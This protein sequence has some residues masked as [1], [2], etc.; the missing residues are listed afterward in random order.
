M[1]PFACDEQIFMAKHS[2]TN[3]V[4]IAPQKNIY[5]NLPWSE[6]M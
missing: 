4:Q 1:L 5:V 2:S 6:S 3:N